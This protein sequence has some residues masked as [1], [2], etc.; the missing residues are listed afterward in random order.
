MD[1]WIVSLQ[2]LRWDLAAKIALAALLGGIVGVER[3]WTGHTAGLRTTILVALGSCL[4]TIL[5]I[6]GFPIKGTSQDTARIAAQ[7][8]SGIGFLGAGA[9]FQSQNRV[10]G[11]T[12]AA[13]IWLVAAIGMAA[14]TG[15]YF[16]ATFTTLMTEVV[17]VVLKPIGD[18]LNARKRRSLG[19]KKPA[20]LGRLLPTDSPEQSDQDF[21]E[22]ES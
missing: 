15:L 6:D 8:V 10:K 7:I 5:S 2:S 22:D 19:G 11:L 9:V 4:F 13:T 14:G 21:D 1:Q 18:W 3:E 20:A 12:T 16:I 17:L